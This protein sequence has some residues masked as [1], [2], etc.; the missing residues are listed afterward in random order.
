MMGGIW[1][2][3]QMAK[4]SRPRVTL[5]KQMWE[6]REKGEEGAA[7]GNAGAHGLTN[8]GILCMRPDGRGEARGRLKDVK[9][10]EKQNSEFMLHLSID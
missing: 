6:E 5:K 10:P 3:H 2:S 7:P 4:H 8:K 1:S 9:R